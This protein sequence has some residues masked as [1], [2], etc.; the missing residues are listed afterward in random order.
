MLYKWLYCKLYKD[1][2]HHPHHQYFHLG[3]LFS[4]HSSPCNAKSTAFSIAK[5]CSTSLARLQVEIELIRA[6][7]QIEKFLGKCLCSFFLFFKANYSVILLMFCGGWLRYV[8]RF[9]HELGADDFQPW[10]V[11]YSYHYHCNCLLL[12]LSSTDD[13]HV[14]LSFLSMS[15]CCP[16]CFHR[17]LVI[18]HKHFIVVY[19]W[20]VAI[21][22]SVQF[23]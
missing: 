7:E 3:I 22:F 23:L 15:M 8:R 16:W 2:L 12:F 18:K 20:I 11:F 13:G 14:K 1:Y 21:K 4:I 9:F 19:G 10:T 17:H 6:I 5:H